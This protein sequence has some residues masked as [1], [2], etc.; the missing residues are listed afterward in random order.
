MEIGRQLGQILYQTYTND[1]ISG[2]KPSD[3]IKICIE[4]LK[5]QSVAEIQVVFKS[6]I[7]DRGMILFEEA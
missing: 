5:D 3:C 7:G 1:F 2:T 4:A 6:D